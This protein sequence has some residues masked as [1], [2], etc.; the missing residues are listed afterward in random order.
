[1]NAVENEEAHK[2]GADIMVA[3]SIGAKN[4][5]VTE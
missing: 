4:E 1:M 3:R 2:R 5:A